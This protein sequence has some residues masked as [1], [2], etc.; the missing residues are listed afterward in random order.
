MLIILLCFAYYIYL[1]Y[2]YQFLITP[3]VHSFMLTHVHDPVRPNQAS[4]EE[5]TYAE[6]PQHQT[7]PFPELHSWR[8]H[9]YSWLGS[10]CVL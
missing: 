1:L 3:I 10:L 9:L 7:E 2:M 8:F 5:A 6:Q 4:T